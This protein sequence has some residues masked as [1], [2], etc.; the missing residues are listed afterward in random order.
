MEN[1]PLN[2][3]AVFSRQFS[4][5]YSDI[6]R[7]AELTLPKIFDY[8]QDIAFI[9][10]D[11]MA[12]AI[13]KKT[14]FDI[15]AVWTQMKGHIDVMPKWKEKI[16]I[17][18]WISPVEKGQHLAYRN[19]AIENQEGTEIGYGYGAFVFFDLKTRRAIP[20]PDS[21]LAYPTF[22]R[23]KDQHPFAGLPSL[24]EESS[25]VTKS[26]EIVAT[27]SDIDLY[28]HVN[29]VRYITWALDGMPHEFLKG[30]RCYDVEIQFKKEMRLR[31]RAQIYTQNAEDE[32]NQLRLQ[33]EIKSL[34]QDTHPSHVFAKLQSHWQKRNVHRQ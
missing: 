34:P 5:P 18:T 15:A 32:P 28:Q 23:Y 20:I 9:H 30:H 12:Y 31:D 17:S 11:R 19:F 21:M 25:N 29:N 27:W 24:A 1:P 6:N 33:H 13:E 2:P 22:D 3:Q 26:S 10:A 8:F 14:E 16:T 4:I 7:F